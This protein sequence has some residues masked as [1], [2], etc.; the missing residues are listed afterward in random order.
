MTGWPILPITM[1]DPSAMKFFIQILPDVPGEMCVCV[2]VCV[3]GGGGCA[4]F[5]VHL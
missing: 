5:V 2:C 1:A 3:C 4:L